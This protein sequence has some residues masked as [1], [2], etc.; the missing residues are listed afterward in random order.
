MLSGEFVASL[1]MEMP[2]ETVPVLVGANWTWNAWFCPAAMETEDIPPTTLKPVPVTVAW[3]MVRDAVPVLVKV[4]VCGLL[5]PAATFPKLRLVA[6]AARVPEELDPEVELLAGVPAPV[7]PTQ[8]AS[9]ITAKHA[10]IRANMPSRAR[11]LGIALEWR[12]VFVWA[13]ISIPA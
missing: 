6:L 10:R 2:P 8:P 13:F 12:R 7:K 3:E 4:K 1:A 9:D 5:D 11:R